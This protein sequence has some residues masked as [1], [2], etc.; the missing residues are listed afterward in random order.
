MF[1]DLV[2]GT[3]IGAIN[4]AIVATDPVAAA[5]TLSHVWTTLDADIILRRGVLRRIFTVAR[6]R[7]Y[8]YDTR[9]LAELV[10]KVLG[11]IAI[12]DL[13]VPYT[14]IALD[15]E[16]ANAVSLTSGPVLS[17]ILASS[18]IPGLFPPVSRDGRLLYDGGLVQNVPITHALD[19]G[20]GSIVVLDCGSADRL[21]APT[22]IA[23]AMLY[24]S[25]VA[26][27]QQLKRDLPDVAEKVP[28]VYLPCPVLPLVSPLDFTRTNQLIESSYATA[29]AFL[30][31]L[32]VEGVG[33]YGMDPIPGPLG[34]L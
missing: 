17:A 5:A 18:A 27:S 10:E 22:S 8:F 24:A 30:A 7:T 9:G 31:T 4:G 29:R 32:H 15:V 6:N 23:T 3:S 12:E 16:S 13:A 21:A 2:V 28:V 26:M 14:A 19:R 1:A 33:F 34:T 11:D 20:A 25:T